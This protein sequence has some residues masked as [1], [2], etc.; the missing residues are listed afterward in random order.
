MLDGVGWTERDKYPMMFLIFEIKKKIQM[1][2]FVEQG[3]THRL[4]EW[5]FGY[6]VGGG[7]G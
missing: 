3:Q 7:E 4:K 6:R 1:N 5:I 2:L